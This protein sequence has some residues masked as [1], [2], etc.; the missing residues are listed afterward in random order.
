[1]PIPAAQPIIVVAP[2]SFKGA[3]DAEG[4]ARAITAGIRTVL[5]DAVVREYPMADGGEGTRAALLY[6]GG[7]CLPLQVQGAGGACRKTIAGLTPEGA[8]IVES[9][10]I[11]G[12]TDPA[13][14]SVPVTARSSAGLG[15]ALSQLLDRG[16]RTCFI[17]LGG[18]STNDGGAGFLSALGVGIFDAAGNRMMPTLD[19]LPHVMR[20]DASGL[21]ARLAKCRLVGMADVDNPLTGPHG[22]THVFGPQKG[23]RADSANAH[24][25]AI[26][27]FARLLEA[28]MGCA[29][30]NAPG[31]GA[32][33]GLG[34][35]IR[36]VGGTLQS[37]ADIVAEQIDLRTALE[38]ADWLITGEGRSDTQT[39]RGKA[40]FAAA[41]R[42][43]AAGVPA[44]LLSGAIARDAG[45]LLG[46][47][48][49]GCF[50]INDG[51]MSLEAAM[52][53]TSI[54]LHNAAAQLTRL[55]FCQ[56]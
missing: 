56:H 27:R 28:A 15:E 41:M 49:A 50:A 45:P 17:A 44:T 18:T 23:I 4:V 51:P 40:P 13:G 16:I 39:L 48:F 11:I 1:M 5:P 33:G 42:A 9:A 38:G 14:M 20:V 34:F 21:D 2:D 35:A 12:I 8:A 29:Y 26:G 32:A 31:A 22:A 43:R 25:A 3:L 30:S 24:D 37:G 36:M 7:E 54:L 55:R 52:A 46:Q 47:H 19:S 10:D 53:D 6:N